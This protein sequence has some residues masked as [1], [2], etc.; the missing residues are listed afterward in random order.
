MENPKYRELKALSLETIDPVCRSDSLE[1]PKYRELKEYPNAMYSV[2][3]Q[4]DS[5]EN[6]KYRELKAVFAFFQ[7]FR[8]K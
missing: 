3:A 7:P 8:I 5:L 2:V 1:N 4:L 6:P